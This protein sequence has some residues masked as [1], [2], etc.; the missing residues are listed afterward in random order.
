MITEYEYRLLS[1]ISEL[2][3]L[4]E[5]DSLSIL[6]YFREIKLRKKEFLLQRDETSKYMNFIAQGGLRSFYIDHLGK[7]HILQLGIEGWWINDL[8]SYLTKTPAK[9]Y[10]QAT[11]NTIVLRIFRD[12]LEMLFNSIPITERFFRLKVQYGYVALQE[13][14]IDRMSRTAEDRYFDFLRK[15]RLLEQRFPQYMI[16]SYL[17]VTPEFLSSLRKRSALSLIS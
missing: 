4:N 7:E 12:D 3:D 10:I 16:A 11:E 17:G 2:V 8:Y 5:A 14:T 6:P 9:Q 15:Y 13:R 1:N